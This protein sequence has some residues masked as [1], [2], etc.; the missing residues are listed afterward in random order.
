MQR[1]ND[2]KR[3]LTLFFKRL[4]NSSH[5]GVKLPATQELHHCNTQ[6]HQQG[7]IEAALIVNC[8][9]GSSAN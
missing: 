8:G 3:E 6:P 5:V 9:T 7:L 2:A 1:A 4:N